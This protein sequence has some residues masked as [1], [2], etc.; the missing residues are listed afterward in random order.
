MTLVG[1]QPSSWK[2]L[3][4]IITASHAVGTMN[5]MTVLAIGPVLQDE[6]SLTATS[7]GL[8]VS[9]YSAMLAFGGL[10]AGTATDRIGVGW[11]LATAKVLLAAGSACLALAHSFPM[12]MMAT[13]LM[14][15][16]YAFV[17]P[18]TSKGVLDWVPQS[19]RGAGMGIKQTG[20]PLGGLLAAGTAVLATTLSWR[21]VL[22]IVSGL[23][24]MSILPCL[25]V[26]RRFR[27]V[28]PATR[29]PIFE[30]WLPLLRNRDLG[31]LNLATG[32]F[33]MC[34][35][36]F[37]TFLP[38]FMR[39][40]IQASQSTAAL[41]LGAAHASGAAGRILWGLVSDRFF[42]TRRKM[43][44]VYICATAALLFV[45]LAS[46]SPSLFWLALA[47]AMGLGLTIGAYAAV[48]Q[49]V[50]VELVQLETAGA[51]TG[52]HLFAL[53]LAG[54]V[55]PPVFG[56]AVDLYGTYAAGWVLLFVIA[57]ASVLILLFGVRNR[58]HG[59]SSLMVKKQD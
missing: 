25:F 33:N 47:V 15:W 19:R 22:W 14:G 37:Y 43:L 40:A 26:A 10:L 27:S 24:L 7:F 53:A 30:T 9:A 41:C 58:V 52:Y 6:L 55:G 20:V 34:Q 35:G 54:I 36:S 31:L 56:A 12:A 45:A 57:I 17:N 32:G 28:M 38:L 59:A 11:A 3:L 2:L 39:E 50:V 46:M 48:A 18:A 23:S 5:I 21:E 29:L 8:L 51:A 42:F 49:I 44:F 4:L 1:I 13:L 16:G